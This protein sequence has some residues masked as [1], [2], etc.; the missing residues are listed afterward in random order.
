[1]TDFLLSQILAGIAICFDMLSFQFK[2]RKKLLGCLFCAC[3]LLSTHFALLEQW[4]A[5]GMLLISTCRYFTSI[6]TTSKKAAAVFIVASLTTTFFT[7]NGITS[8]L[9][10]SASVL[11][12]TAAFNKND[13]T[14]RLL[15]M[16]GICLWI[17]HNTLVQSPMAV[18]VEVLFMASNLV[19]FYRYYLRPAL[20]PVDVL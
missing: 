12:T 4:T 10:C 18:V 13:K 9:S 17:T 3:I 5:A 2:D 15:M 20:G 6:F 11:Q 8:V 7:F 1:M 16:A 14:L 19:G